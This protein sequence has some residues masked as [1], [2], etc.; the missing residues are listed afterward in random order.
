MVKL[1]AE[2]GIN[3]NGNM[4]IV[5][6][7]IDICSSAGIDFVKFQKRNPDISVPEEMKN[8]RRWTPWGTM[9][10]LD[11]KYKM[12]LSENQYK[13]IDDYCR[14]KEINWFASVWDIDSA[15]FLEKLLC[16]IVKIPSAKITDHTLLDY[17]RKVFPIRIMSTGMSTEEEI[18]QAI[19]IYEPDV[20]M[21]CNSSYPASIE[22]LNL[23]YIKWLK[24][25]YKGRDIGYSG[26]EYGLITT[27]VTI[28]MGVTW[29]ER[30]V[31]L[32]RTMWGSDQTSSI[33]PTGIF[34]FVKGVRDIEKA[35]G[36]P[37]K[38]KVYKSEIEKRKQLR[39]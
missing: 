27:F 17:C 14:E 26:H 9:T 8:S 15:K 21:H 3:H 19:N 22:E 24:N 13:E 6:K 23:N 10:Y 1:I 38:R 12:E 29:I 11:Y 31:T 37:E 28:P 33:E 30:H 16:G 36:V 25:K 2:I 32:D 7:L 39:G 18:D 20:I 5:K 4:N 35:M 34:K